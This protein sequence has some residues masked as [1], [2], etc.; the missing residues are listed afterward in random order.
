LHYPPTKERERERYGFSIENILLAIYSE[1][2]FVIPA[3]ERLNHTMK[4]CIQTNGMN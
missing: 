4:A 1:K 3:P 2:R